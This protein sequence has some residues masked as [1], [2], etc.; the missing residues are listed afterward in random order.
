M[1][2]MTLSNESLRL[3]CSFCGNFLY[4]TSKKILTCLHCRAVKY[5][6][7]FEDEKHNRYHEMGTDPNQTG[8]V[9]VFFNL[10]EERT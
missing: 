1:N 8:F 7:K 6:G 4:E 5:N 2:T 10:K 3:I 9:S